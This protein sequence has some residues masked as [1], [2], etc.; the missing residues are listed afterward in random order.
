MAPCWSSSA[1]ITC[2]GSRNWW[3]RPIA[4]LWASDSA[5]WNL[6]VSLSI[7]MAGVLY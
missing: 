5:I 3:S 4:R 1:A 7:L 6:V 2:T